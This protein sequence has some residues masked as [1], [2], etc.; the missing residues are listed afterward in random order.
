MAKWAAFIGCLLL[1]ACGPS[2]SS[3]GERSAGQT[4]AAPAAAPAPATASS[5]EPARRLATHDLSVDE[6]MG[7]HTLSKHVGR[8]DAQLL[9][10][11]RDEPGISAASTYTDRTAAERSVDGALQAGGRKLE[12]WRARRGTRPNL[13]LYY[14]SRADDPIGRSIERGSHV[15]VPC[16]RAIVV[17]RWDDRRNREFVLT[18]YPEAGR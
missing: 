6:T 12:T 13:T 18:S 17:V 2:P 15:A 10:R 3:S 14:T 7:G 5:A 8:S 16:H 1:A 9:Q 11:L 4:P